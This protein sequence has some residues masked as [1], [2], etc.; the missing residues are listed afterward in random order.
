RFDRVVAVADHGEGV[1]EVEAFKGA[2]P[3]LVVGSSW[4]S[5][6]AVLAPLIRQCTPHWKV[7][8]AP[9][10]TEPDRISDLVR[11]LGVPSLKWSSLER[12]KQATPAAAVLIIDHTGLLSRIYRYADVAY[13]GGGFHTGIH[14]ILE[15]AV[16]GVPVVF[17]PRHQKFREALALLEQ[18]GAFA[19]DSTAALQRVFEQLERDA[20][21]RHQAGVAAGNY[22]RVHQGATAQIV[23]ALIPMLEP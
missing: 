2:S 21:A 12:D 16:F 13:I 19:V 20:P 18:G 4:P 8:I 5:D 9:H 22:V 23:R 6:E 15:A 11:A 3:M 10:E 1:P 14:N 17:G 7:V